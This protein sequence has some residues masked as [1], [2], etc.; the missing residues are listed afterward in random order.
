MY[1][2]KGNRSL[3]GNMGTVLWVFD[4]I[5]NLEFESWAFVFR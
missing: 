4:R 2:K 3:T 5:K 1:A